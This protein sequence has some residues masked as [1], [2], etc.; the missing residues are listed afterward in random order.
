MCICRIIFLTGVSNNHNDSFPFSLPFASFCALHCFR[1]ARSA[2]GGGGVWS[3]QGAARLCGKPADVEERGMKTS[4]SA[5]LPPPRLG[6]ES[7]L[8]ASGMGPRQDGPTGPGLPKRCWPGLPGICRGCAPFSSMWAREHASS[9]PY[10]RKTGRRRH[11]LGSRG[12][13]RHPQ[14]AFGDTPTG[15]S[16]GYTPTGGSFGLV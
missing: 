10:R 6:H 16:F 14:T 12:T 5:A 3:S 7:A 4:P 13:A 11:P 15:L 8:L 2:R 9:R 1:R